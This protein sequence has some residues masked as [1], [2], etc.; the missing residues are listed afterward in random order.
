MQILN[1]FGEELTRREILSIA[2]AAVSPLAMLLNDSLEPASDHEFY[3][4]SIADG[5]PLDYLIS[6]EEEDEEYLGL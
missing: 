6:L 2:D 4:Q 5:D 1:S 3:F